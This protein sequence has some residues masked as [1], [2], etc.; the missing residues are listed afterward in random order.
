MAQ[1]Q[2]K[3]TI[4]KRERPQDGIDR[5]LTAVQERHRKYMGWFL[6]E[7]QRQAANRNLMAKCEA[8][9]DNEQ[10]SKEVAEE[11]RERGQP[12]VQHNEVKPTIDWMIGTEARARPDFVVVAE[13]EGEEAD[14][15]ALTKTKLLKYLNATNKAEFERSAAAKFMFKAGLG[16]IEVGIR[17]DRSGPVVLISADSWRNHLHDSQAQKMDHSDGRYHFRIKVLDLDVV[18]AIFPDKKREVQT[19]VQDGDDFSSMSSNLGGLISGLDHFSGNWE[20]DDHYSVRPVDL[21][22]PRRRVMLIECWS[23]EPVIRPLDGEGLGDPV[24]WEIHVTIMTENDILLE[25]VSPFKHDRFPFIP[26]YAYRNSRTGLPYSPIAALISPQESLNHR[27]A[28][29]VWEAAKNQLKVESSAID[30]Q[31]MDIEELRA[32]LDDPNGIAVF[33][34]GALSGNRVQE[35]DDLG[36]AQKQLALA[37]RDINSIR[38]M[39]GV[40]GENRGLDTTATSGKAV[41]AKADQGS[42]LTAELFD[43]LL[44]ARQLEGELTLSMAEQFMVTPRTIRVPGEKWERVKI[45]EPQADGSYRNDLAARRAHFVVGEQAW[46]QSYAE[47]AFEQLMQVFT[48]LSAAAP[49]VVIAMLDVLFEIH[50]NLPKKQALLQRI[51][52]VTG[53]ADPDGKLTPDQM[54]AQQMQQARAQA[55]FQAEMAQLRAQVKEAEAKGE[56]L[57]AEGMAKRLETIY[58]AAQAAQVAVQVPGAMP[59]A[60]QLLKSSG[61][62]DRDGGQVAQV[63]PGQAEPAATNPIPDP[64]Q[65]DGAMQGIETLAPDGVQP[66]A[67][68]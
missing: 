67:M 17:A 57:E 27:M 31:V 28:R 44:F 18:E 49:N 8:F 25:G 65:A 3:R 37:E 10:I 20:P 16:F 59:V 48:Q 33:K 43:N 24:S 32:E 58:M 5:S 68:Q 56:K 50:P 36:K 51:R 6:H 1:P 22:N 39:S 63:P 62:V 34:D 41:L 55:Q 29:S 2:L 46:K 4:P 60:D 66:G 42:L 13:D 26:V 15:D 47:A 12:I 38:Q 54:A 23:R 53:Q 35:R 7:A 45:N 9:Y 64:L 52:S 19:V 11:L 21:W 40:T 61:F 14:E 30:P